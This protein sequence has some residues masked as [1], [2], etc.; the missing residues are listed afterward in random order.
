MVRRLTAVFL[1]TSVTMAGCSGNG[2]SPSSTSAPG[3]F[4]GTWAGT[5]GTT[6]VPITITL[7]QT[8]SA[9]SGTLTITSGPGAGQ[10]RINGTATGSTANVTMTNPDGTAVPVTNVTFTLNGSAMSTSWVSSSG[11]VITGSLTGNAAPVSAPPAST[12][13]YD[14]T[15]N[16]FFKYPSPNGIASS[17]LSNYLIIRNSVV[18]SSDGAAAGSVTSLGNITFTTPCPINSSTA[19]WT[20]VMNASALA[21]ANFGQGTYTC[22]IAI[23]GGSND[24]W[25]ATQS[26]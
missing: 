24:T 12:A 19:T 21:G 4:N 6:P 8:V 10:V 13:K 18:S 2:S 1:L 20:G 3:P 23:G 7:T 22:S 11:V 16:F 25:Q 17:N 9:V 26:K 14:G 5:F 15:Y